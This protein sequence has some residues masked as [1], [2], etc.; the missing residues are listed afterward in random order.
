[1]RV[2]SEYMPARGRCVSTKDSSSSGSSDSPELVEASSVRAWLRRSCARVQGDLV[3]GD[4]E[5]AVVPMFVSEE[6]G[7]SGVAVSRWWC[8]RTARAGR[9]SKATGQGGLN[10]KPPPGVPSL[11]PGPR[12]PWPSETAHD[13]LARRTAREWRTMARSSTQR[14]VPRFPCTVMHM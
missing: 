10:Q 5:V 1:M 2:Y 14:P 8:T 3:A 9:N 11:A 6:R 7:I 4:R 12:L 13:A